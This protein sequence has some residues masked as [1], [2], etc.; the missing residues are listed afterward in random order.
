[1]KRLSLLLVLLLAACGAENTA[2]L[3]TEVQIPT[4]TPTLTPLPTET[5]TNTPLPTWT[6][7]A[8]RTPTP[9][10]TPTL[11]PSDTPLPSNTPTRTL[12]PTRTSTPT[13][14]DTP[15]PS[16]TATLPVPVISQ[17]EVSPERV[18]QGREVEISWQADADMVLLQVLD[19][20]ARPIQAVSLAT[21]GERTITLPE[22][23]EDIAILSLQARRGES[24]ARQDRSVVVLCGTTWFFPV[25]VTTEVGCP[26]AAAISS[27]GRYQIFERG[28][29]VY[30]PTTNQ[31]YALYGGSNTGTWEAY[32]NAGGGSL[33][34]TAPD[35][36][37]NAQDEFT[38]TWNSLEAPTQ[39]LWRD[40][41]GYGT[42]PATQTT[43]SVQDERGTNVFY[44]GTGDGLLLKMTFYP[45]QATVGTWQRVR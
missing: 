29:M 11:T 37:F 7:T 20:Q 35:N 40:E 30:V 13:P 22:G 1:M 19:A 9:T 27:N 44:I 10:R 25:E 38:Y 39:R 41:I 2:Q 28:Y 18:E 16:A 5:S 31:V 43:V 36:R 21:A 42:S 6:A 32:G 26:Q 8:S 24:T 33:V 4:R 34:G 15:I 17:F 3:P 45:Q 14:S 23:L 12:V